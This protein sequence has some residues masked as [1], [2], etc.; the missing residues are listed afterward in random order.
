M[1]TNPLISNKNETS[2]VNSLVPVSN[3]NSNNNNNSLSSSSTANPN[4]TTTLNKPKPV[5]D[6]KFVCQVCNK[7]F[8]AK[9]HLIV[10]M[11]IHTGERPYVCTYNDCGKAFKEKS[12]LNR[13][14]KIHL[15]YKPFKCRFCSYCARE[16]TT[17][18]NHE[19]ACQTRQ[20]RALSKQQ[21][22]M[23]AQNAK[24]ARQNQNNQSQIST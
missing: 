10:H 16:R 15:N 11:R 2:L 17:L 1:G 9:T 12:N 6:R 23:N 3:N 22:K 14:M 21:A 18:N 7:P 4:T 24:M 19:K 13:H 5:R 8:F 20:L